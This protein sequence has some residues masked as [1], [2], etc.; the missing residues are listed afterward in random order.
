VR[1]CVCVCARACACLCACV[2]MRAWVRL[3]LFLP[4]SFALRPDAFLASL[5]FFT[6]RCVCAASGTAAC[7]TTLARSSNISIDPVATARPLRCLLPITRGQGEVYGGI[8][9]V[10][11]KPFAIKEIAKSSIMV[12]A[13]TGASRVR[14]SGFTSSSPVAASLISA[15]SRAQQHRCR[16]TQALLWNERAALITMVRARVPAFALPA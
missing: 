10:T 11:G 8:H 1:V 9:E 15:A 14:T 12:G 5:L 16:V 3:F 7:S 2:C 4:P 6:P 13:Q